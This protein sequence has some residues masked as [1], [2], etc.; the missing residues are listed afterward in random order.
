MFGNMHRVPSE[1]VVNIHLLLVVGV[2]HFSLLLIYQME[3]GAC[4]HGP[5]QWSWSLSLEPEGSQV[6]WFVQVR[7][8]NRD[9]LVGGGDVGVV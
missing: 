7:D 3:L 2:L 5:R 6:P 1:F 9:F 8:L 4:D